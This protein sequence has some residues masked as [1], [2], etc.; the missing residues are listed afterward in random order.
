MAGARDAHA[1]APADTRTSSRGRRRMVSA[2]A[3]RASRRRGRR[4]RAAAPPRWRPRRASWPR[5][6]AHARVG[7]RRRLGGAR[8]TEFTTTTERFIPVVTKFHWHVTRARDQTFQSLLTLGGKG[9]RWVA[10]PSGADPQYKSRAVMG[11]RAG[12][13]VPAAPTD[14]TG[15]RADAFGSNYRRS[16]ASAA[17]LGR[18]DARSPS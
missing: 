12:R 8:A 6:P 17:A 3:S 5:L 15:R 9:S 1:R 11:A 16:L 10:A 13:A 18:R 2:T 7:P 14:R 4:R